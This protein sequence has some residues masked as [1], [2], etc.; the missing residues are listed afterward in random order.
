M[1]DGPLIV[2][3]DKTLLLEVDHPKADE[4]RRAIAPFAELERAPE[5]VHTYRVTPLALWNARA[6]GHDAEQVVDALLGYSRYPVPHALL[7]DVAE[8]MARYGRLR[9]E[10]HPAHGL[11]LTTTDRAVLEEVLRSRKIQPMLGERLG[12]D[13]VAVHPSERG[14]IKQALLK[15]GWPAEDLAG[16]VDGEHHPIAL[17]E[18]GWALRAYQREAADAFWH[19]GSGVVVLPCGAGK[20]IVGAAAMA[21]A[22]ATTL[23]L[24]T[25]T[26]SAHQWKAELL[27]RT[28]LTENEIGEYS[29]SRKEIRPVTIATY[30]VMTTRRK[31]VYPHLELFDARDWGLI[32]YDEVHLLPAPIFRMTA[33]LQARRRLGLTATLVR[34]DGREGDVFS[35]IGPKRY[36]APWKEMENQGWIAPADCVEVRVTLTDEERLAYAMAEAEERYRFCATTPSKTRVTEALVRRHLGEQVL[37]IGQYIDQLDELAE[38]LGAPV[39]KGE[40]R[41]KER[42][43]LFQAFRDKE[44]QV[45]VVSKV[46]NFSIDLPEASV[47]IQVSG[48]FGSRQEEAQRLGRILRPKA[49]GGGARFYTVVS[50]DTVDQEFAAHRQR[51]LA[52]QGYAYQIVDADDVLA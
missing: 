25:N 43:R 51:F 8:T 20:T 49:D 48:T 24:V 42:E 17:A 31:G 38:H 5:H 11:M 10:K 35:L 1:N 52:E 16:Y 46:A 29:G 34:E 14:N 18:D 22:Q 50:R 39:I 36:D 26:V 4:C 15:L 3:S 19:G 47:A 37:V 41:V 27:R 40:T 21:H 33:D 9:L 13:S 2:Q 30:Q 44:L 7:V 23:I 45:L 28:S 12:E 6:A 32:V